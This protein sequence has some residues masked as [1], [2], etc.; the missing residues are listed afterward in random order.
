MLC[1]PRAG[2]TRVVDD[3]RPGL[4][5]ITE[6]AVFLDWYWLKAELVDHCRSV[7]LSTQGSK[8]E[9]TARIAHFLA[10]GERRG[11]KRP[12]RPTSSFDWANAEITRDTTITDSYR[13]GP[14]VRRFFESQI[15]PRFSFSIE[16]MAWM[17]G[18]AGRTMADAVEEWLAIEARRQDGERAAIPP[19]N[20]F[21]R[22]VRDFFDA[23][24]ERSMADA[25]TCW[26]AKRNRPGGNR[27]E[28]A[29][30]DVLG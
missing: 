12:E 3:T 18:N 23:N 4:A 25:R 24:P 14:N 5:E 8:A 10:T 16:F 13:N 17:K 6:S 26:M 29:D 19:D 27:Y 2:E 20:Q 11:P 22:Y 28:T 7:G 9:L 15:G 1:H 30:L 21:N